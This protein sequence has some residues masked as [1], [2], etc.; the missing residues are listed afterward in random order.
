M[1]GPN[2]PSVYQHILKS[3]NPETNASIS[4][5]NEKYQK[6]S[7][8]YTNHSEDPSI[9]DKGYLYDEID[10]I[11]FELQ[12]K[13]KKPSKRRSSISFLSNLLF[14]RKQSRPISVSSFHQI[15]SMPAPEDITTGSEYTP[16]METLTISDAAS[17]G[18]G[19]VSARPY[20]WPHDSSLDKS[21]TAL[22]I[23][24]MQKDCKSG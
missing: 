11:K 22:V 6:L 9:R 17:L 2:D 5:V 12:A 20:N 23:V 7:K 3:S 21:T 13:V 19:Q 4:P 1:E 15:F 10:D 16:D 14:H 18:D 24:D 8:T